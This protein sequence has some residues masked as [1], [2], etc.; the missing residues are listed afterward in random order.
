MSDIHNNTETSAQDSATKDSKVEKVIAEVVDSRNSNSSDS[1]KSDNTNSTK[2]INLANIIK[3]LDLYLVQKAPSLPKNVKDFCFKYY[4]L[5]TKISLVL[6]G[7]TS[8]FTLFVLVY[9]PIWT[10]LSLV[11]D[12]IIAFYCWKALPKLE[13]SEYEGWLDIFKG[14]LFSFA[15]SF[16]TNLL[17]SGVINTIIIYAVFVTISFYIHFQIR[18]YYKIK[19]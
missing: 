7:I 18:S 6:I 1:N 11:S 10:I 4:P 17:Y 12:A 14:C 5:L 13:K 8:F 3:F 9:A 16:L 19:A 15:V 2:E